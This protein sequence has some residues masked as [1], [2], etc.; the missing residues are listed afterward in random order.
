MHPVK[1]LFRIIQYHPNH[2]FYNDS[3]NW[4]PWRTFRIGIRNFFL[5]QSEKRFESR[6]LQ[7]D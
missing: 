6:S 1:K 3:S 5:N 7:T 4:L 2:Y